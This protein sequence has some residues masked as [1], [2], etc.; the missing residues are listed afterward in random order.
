MIVHVDD[1]ALARSQLLHNYAH[2]L[3]WNIN[4][5]MFNR[6]HQLAINTFGDNLRLTDHQFIAFAAHHFDQDWKL[7]LATTHHDESVGRAGIFHA[8]WDIGEQ[9]LLQAFAKMTRSN[10]SAFAPGEWR[11]IHRELHGYCRLIDGDRRQR[12]WILRV[13]YGLADG[14][15]LDSGH[16]NNIAKFSFGDV[17][18][19]QAGKWKQ[20]SDFSFLQRAIKF[21]DAYFFAIVHGP[22]EHTRDGKTSEV[23]AVVE[24]GDQDLQRTRSL[25]RRRRDGIHDG[26]KQR[27]QIFR[28]PA[29]LRGSGPGFGIGIQNGK[30][31]LVLFGV[32]INE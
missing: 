22:V 25:S 19:L 24:I 26:F 12:R 32:E 14:D 2:K 6:L 30:I 10:K 15:A 5:E 29:L 9:F 8:Q 27:L 7:Q 1:F 23:V 13:G 31:E 28:P 3:F 21:R 16:S 18:P 11:H 4:R 20:L 17:R